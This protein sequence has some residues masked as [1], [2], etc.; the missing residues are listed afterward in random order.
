[1]GFSAVLCLNLSKSTPVSYGTGVRLQQSCP[2]RF[3]GLLEASSTVS[4]ICNNMITF[5]MHSKAGKANIGLLS[6]LE[7][8]EYTLEETDK[9]SIQ[10]VPTLRA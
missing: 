6:V 2:L 5:T 4:I 8:V 3:P 7:V 1:M 10:I 9:G